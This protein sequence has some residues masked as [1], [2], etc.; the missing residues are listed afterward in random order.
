MSCKRRT[1]G[2]VEVEVLQLTL[3]VSMW[4]GLILGYGLGLGWGL[5]FGLGSDIEV[6][7][8]NKRDGGCERSFTTLVESTCLG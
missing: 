3:V 6:E 1:L 5:G 2:S 4:F 8:M 7:I